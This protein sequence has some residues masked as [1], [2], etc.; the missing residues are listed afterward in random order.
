MLNSCINEEAGFRPQPLK[1]GF[2]GGD[3]ALKLCV[4]QF[5]KHSR[6]RQPHLPGSGASALFI[7]EQHVRPQREG[8]NNGFVF[9][10]VEWKCKLRQWPGEFSTSSQPSVIAAVSCALA[11]AWVRQDTSAATAGEIRTTSYRRLSKSSLPIIARLERGEVLLTARMSDVSHGLGHAVLPGNAP[12]R[13]GD[14][15]R[16]LIQTGQPRSHTQGKP[17]LRVKP[18]GDFNLHLPFAL[19]GTKREGREGLFIQV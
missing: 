19:S 12:F 11:A 17:P 13:E 7:N 2:E 1:F 9:A 8:E 18:A 15:K 14:A 4:E 16:V 5:P 10:W 6:H 3:C